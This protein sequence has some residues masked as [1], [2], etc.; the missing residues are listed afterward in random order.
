MDPY[1]PDLDGKNI[2]FRGQVYRMMKIADGTYIV[3]KEIPFDQVDEMEE[4]LE[5]TSPYNPDND[6]ALYPNEHIFRAQKGRRDSISEKSYCGSAEHIRR[7]LMLQMIHDKFYPD[8]HFQQPFRS[9]GKLGLSA[10]CFAKGRALGSALRS[11]GRGG[12][13][14]EWIKSTSSSP[15][16]IFWTYSQAQK[17]INLS[18]TNEKK[19]QS[20]T[21]NIE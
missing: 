18:S 3:A 17:S 4:F 13:R 9:Y 7:A 11:G 21:M 5:Y 2:R 8:H 6:D 12:D 10:T 16:Q 1:F 20:F 19:T 15:P 14:Q